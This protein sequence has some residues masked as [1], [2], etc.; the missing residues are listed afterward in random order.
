MIIFHCAKLNVFCY[1]AVLLFLNMFGDFNHT[2]E[3]IGAGKIKLAETLLKTT[4]N[5]YK[6]LNYSSGKLIKVGNVFNHSVFIL[7][8]GKHKEIVLKALRGYNKIFFDNKKNVF[9]YNLSKHINN[10]F[11]WG[12]L[13]YHRGLHSLSEKLFLKGINKDRQYIETELKAFLNETVKKINYIDEG[14]FK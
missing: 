4:L 10:Y 11:Y 9:C 1:L 7:E 3:K 12:E 13:L 5:E 2:A 14:R 8:R 6:K